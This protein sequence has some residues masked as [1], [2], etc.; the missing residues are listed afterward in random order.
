MVACLL[1]A[2]ASIGC[3][4]NTTPAGVPPDP[5]TAI[6]PDGR[7][8]LR[9]TIDRTTLRP[10]DDI[11]GTAEL[12]LKAGGSGA[13]TGPDQMF[14]FEFVE[15]G[16]EHRSVFP[17]WDAVCSPHQVGQDQPLTA[18]LARSG[19]A[20]DEF[21]TTFLQG[22]E[23]HLPAGQWDI[24]AIVRFHEGRDCGGLR[25][26]PRATVRVTVNE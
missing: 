18:E 1:V 24:S 26:E 23:I 3:A 16:G 22:T 10:G 20:A 11:T 12:W 21:T 25:H 6:T 13:I 19:A 14:G 7:F 2:L 9:F 8:E 4:S 17:V 15:V 5:V